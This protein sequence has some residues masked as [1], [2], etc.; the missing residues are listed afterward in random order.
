MDADDLTATERTLLV[1]VWL[2]RHGQTA[3]S[4]AARYTGW[5][6]VALTAAGEA[7]ARELAPLLPAGPDVT[8]W[9]SDLDRCVRTAQLA[10]LEPRIDRRLR[11]LDFGE[12]D[13]LTWEQLSE[14]HRSAVVAFEDFAAP[15]GE[16]VSQL[17]ARVHA[18]F[19][20]LEP[21]RH[22]VVTHGGVVRSLLREV[23]RDGAVAPAQVEHLVWPLAP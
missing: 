19:E 21:G 16:S 18:F 1:E 12:L 9:S 4:D 14:A 10:G 5:S 15:G 20:E 7:R 23:G 6:D 17:R 11:E 2:V 13:G 8:A 3:W 22:I